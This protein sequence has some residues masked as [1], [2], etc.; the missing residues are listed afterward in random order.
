MQKYIPWADG[1]FDKFGVHHMRQT[2]VHTERYHLVDG[3]VVYDNVS[4]VELRQLKSDIESIIKI[5]H[6]N[7]IDKSLDCWY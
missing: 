5:N 6:I 1:R 3:Q 7:L 4:R 2:Y